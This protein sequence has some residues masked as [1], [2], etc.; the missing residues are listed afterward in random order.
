MPE[1]PVPLLEPTTTKEKEYKEILAVMNLAHEI[2]LRPTR[3]QEAYFRRACGVARFTYNWALEEWKRQHEAGDKPSGIAL[4]REFNAIRRSK[5]PWTYE[6]H[7]DCTARP[8]ANVQTAFNNFFRRVKA[9]ASKDEIGF[10]KY[11]KRGKCKDS[12]YVS[13]DKLKLSGKTVRLPHLG[14]VRMREALR[15]DDKVMSATVKRIADGWYLV[16]Q[17]DV[18]DYRRD[19]TADGQVGVDLGIKASATLSTGEQFDSP[20]PLRKALKRLQR[21]SRQHS[22]KKKGS[23]NRRKA[24]MKLSRLHRR[25][26][27]VRSDF[28]HKLTTKL[29]RE[30]QA[31]GVEDLAVG[32][33]VKNHHLARC[34]ADEGWGEF[35]RQLEYKVVIYDDEIVVH[36]RW[37]PS[38]KTCFACG[39]KK[40]S[41][42]LAERTYTCECGWSVD[43]DV[44][45]A[46]NCLPW[47]ARE[48]TPVEREALA[49]AAVK[50]L[51]SKQELSGEHSCSS[52]RKQRR[53]H[54]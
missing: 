7:K 51:S 27:C 16:V 28:L 53:N 25:V 18:G 33:M 24:T 38:S 42:S 49:A 2:R 40:E 41:L 43:R 6:V 26:A 46:L 47:V 14:I 22:R 13:N 10:P 19:R 39:K 54:E 21:V 23:A 48:V 34:I 44:N 1:V 15:F 12:F 35:R 50:L 32:N 9:G 3:T 37:Y 45:A 29:C 11:K 36:D 8:F 20:K 5:Y 4:K 52:G 31:I 17:V 30:N